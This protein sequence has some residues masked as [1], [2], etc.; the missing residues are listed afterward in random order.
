MTDPHTQGQQTAPK[1]AL[2]TKVLVLFL[3]AMILANIGGEND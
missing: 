3:I 2:F 1:T